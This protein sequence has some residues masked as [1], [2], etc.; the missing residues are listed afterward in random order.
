M[1]VDILNISGTWRQ[2]AD[3][4]R[5]TINKDV[6]TTEPSSNWKTKLLISEHSPIRKL[7]IS[8]KWKDL[9]YYVSTHFVRHK[10]G[11]EHW[12]STQRTDRTGIDR[13]ALQQ[14]ALVTHES[15]ANAQS[16]INISKTRLCMQ[17]SKE[18]R[19][20]WQEFLESIKEKEPEL[21]NVC[22]PSCVYRCSCPEFKSCGVF[23]K[24]YACCT[25]GE[26]AN[27][28]SRYQIY[29]DIKEDWN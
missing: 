19:E 7:R 17:A 9:K 26:L 10:Y 21:Y 20:A 22:V 11:I 5:T 2:I 8:W 4:C 15:E 13:E 23:N 14:S 1:K 6:G 28:E 18:T 25:K 3:A 24:V 27:I 12:V 29:H 16:I